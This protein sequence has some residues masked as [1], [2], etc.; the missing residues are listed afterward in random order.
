MS[1]NQTFRHYR[2]SQDPKGG[3]VEIWR[4]GS[5]VVCLAVD[6]LRQVFVELHVG[7]SDPGIARE[8]KPF[9]QIA[10]Q[11][12]QLRHRHLLNI[13]DSGEDEGANYFVTEFID[14]E[15]LD[16]FLARCNPLPPWLALQVLGNLVDG[17]QPLSQHPVLL[18]GTDLFNSTIQLL[19]ETPQDLLCKVA[20]LNLTVEPPKSALQLSASTQRLITDSSR[21]LFYMLTGKMTEAAPSAQD[22]ATLPAELGFL[23]TAISSP[24]HQH[25]PTSLDQLRNLVERCRKDLPEEASRVPEKL[26][27]S[28]R[29]RL[30][31]QAHFTQP[32]TLA[33]V[34]SEDFQVDPTPFDSA[35][36]YRHLATTR[37]TRAPATIQ[38]LPPERLMPREYTRSLRTAIQRINSLDHPHLIRVIG[39]A[40][41]DHPEFFIEEATGRH[42]LAS[43]LRLKGGLNASEAVMMLEHLL[44][45]TRQAEG[46]GLTP[47]FR[48]PGQIYFHFTAASGEAKLPPDTELARLPLH[49]W[50]AFRLRVRTYATTLNLAQPERFNPDRLLPA[51][52]P[53][54]ET[55]PNQKLSALFTQATTRDFALLAAAMTQGNS[56]VSEKIRHHIFDNLRNRKPNQQ[57]TPK[58]F[59]ERLSALAGRPVVA[60]PKPAP[61]KKAAPRKKKPT[62]Q[63][64]LPLPFDEGVAFAPPSDE[65]DYLQEGPGSIPLGSESHAYAPEVSSA[66]GFAEMLFGNQL[67]PEEYSEPAQHPA[68]IFSQG[69]LLPPP[70]GERNFLDGPLDHDP[71]ADDY[72]Y[73]DE[74]EKKGPSILMLLLLI[75][76]VAAVVAGIMAHFTGRAFWLHK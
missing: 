31:L 4:S 68:T 3:A 76:L 66:P 46:C 1:A 48:S 24:S 58:E 50:P 32:A 2:I 51:G 64:E 35:N 49:E 33:D 5:E 43:V 21:L 9:Q 7:I 30:P 44:E 19:G 42:S 72:S 71:V 70:G 13:L 20:D 38:L 10:G 15:R 17:L 52:H 60:A 14:G 39:Y 27:T 62:A 34:L 56:E 36:P 45:A 41:S 11:A 65:P 74:P 28:L 12:T 47:V 63:E 16:T 55:A 6:T 22:V 75:I 67:P 61:A 26:S 57:S 29:P 40:E 23:L 37:S 54:T 18:A 73:L 8:H 69:P 25:H 53:G 59:I